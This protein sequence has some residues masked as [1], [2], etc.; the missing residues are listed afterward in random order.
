M[1]ED[2]EEWQ[3]ARKRKG[4]TRKTKLQV[5]INASSNQEHLDIDKTV[6]RLKE[7]V[8]KM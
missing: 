6:K 4:K 1:S 3:V 7:T 8:V 2:S 5:S